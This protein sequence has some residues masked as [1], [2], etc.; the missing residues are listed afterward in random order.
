MESNADCTIALSNTDLEPAQ[1]KISCPP[2]AGPLDPDTGASRNFPPLAVTALSIRCISLS[3]RVA[4]S[5]ITLP[6]VTPASVPPDAS[7]NTAALAS[8]VESMEKTISQS[9]TTSLAD[10]LISIFLS[11]NFDFRPSH[12]D[13]VL[14]HTTSGMSDVPAMSSFRMQPTMPS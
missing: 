12:L 6:S 3:A 8:G 13:E 9:D 1:R 10:D 14:F 11:G 2:C 7:S 4:Q 5:M